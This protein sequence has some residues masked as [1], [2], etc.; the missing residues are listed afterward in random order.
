MDIVG[1][2]SVA[3]FVLNNSDIGEGIILNKEAYI[4]QSQI[5]LSTLGFL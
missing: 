1:Y 3:L 5:E 4:K 2:N